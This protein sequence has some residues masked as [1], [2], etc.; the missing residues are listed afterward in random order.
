L[1]IAHVDVTRYLDPYGARVVRRPVL[2]ELTHHSYPIE[3][4]AEQSW[5]ALAFRA[6]SAIANTRTVRDL[7]IVGTGNGLDALGALEIFDPR[8]LTVTD[9]HAE[10]V[11]VAR[12]NVLVHVE[13]PSGTE[14]SFHAGDLLSCVPPAKR[15]CLI[16]E[17]LPN[18][19]ADAGIDLRLGTIAGRFFDA[20]DLEVPELFE[21]HLLALH[22]LC[23]QQ[24]RGYLRDGGGVLTALGG[25]VPL[26]VAFDL[27]RACGYHPE[28]V[29]FDVK[30]QSE[31]ELVLPGYCHA[32]AQYGVEFTFHAPQALACVAEGRRSGLEG[33]DLADAVE[34]ELRGYAMPAHEALRRCRRGEAV[35]HT[36]FEVLGELRPGSEPPHT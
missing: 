33:R 11:S 6:F 22:Y 35:A 17:N 29:A 32:E 36:V 19:R 23:L 27:H 1:Q 21:T 9:L 4:S 26:E 24:A 28:L 20:P 25:R 31:P 15:F 7:L 5:L 8:S 2:L 30:P 13:D 16:Y 12:R 3:P 34:A 18:V 10:S 14:I